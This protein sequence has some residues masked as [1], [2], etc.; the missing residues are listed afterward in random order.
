MAQ[1]TGLRRTCIAAAVLAATSLASGTALGQEGAALEEIVITGTRIANPNAASSSPVLAVTQENIRLQG[2]VDAG[3]LVDTLPQQITTVI[4]LSNTNNPLSGP[5]GITTMNLRGLGPQRTLVL[6]DGRRLGVGDPNSGNPNPSPDINQI[7]SALIERVDIVTGGASA[8]YGSDAI[9]GVA[10]FIMRR[11]F[12]G[13]Q[14]DAQ[15]GFNWHD[16]SNDYMQDLL[17]DGDLPSPSSNSTDGDELSVSVVVGGNFADGKGNA[18]GYLSYINANPT[19]LSER[20][21]SSCQLQGGG[22]FCGGSANS[23]YFEVLNGPAAG[24]LYSVFGEDLIDHPLVTGTD[25]GTNPPPLFNSNPYMNL[26]HG[27]ERYQGGVF[28]KYEW[29]E[30]ATLYTDFMF[31]KDQADTAVAPSGLFIGD[32]LPVFCNN[33]LLSAQQ[34]TAIGCTPA[35]IAAGDT[36]DMLIGR[37]NIEGGPRSFEYDHTNYRAMMGVRGDLNDA[38]SYDA[39][40][41]YYDTDLSNGNYGYIS[42]TRTL[43]GLNGCQQSADPT[44][45]AAGCVP[46]NIWRDGGVT[47]AA[48]DYIFAYGLATGTATQA[49]ANAGMTGDL[50][51]YGVQLPTAEEGVGVAFGA[52]YRRDTFGFTPDQTLGSG[53]LSGSGGASPTIN[54]D[55]DVTE[56]YAE[57][58]VPLVQGRAGA[59]DL[60]FET[61]YRYS[62]YEL[63]G[64]VDT[65]KFGLQWAPVESIRLRGSYN[66]AIRAPS[67]IELFN[68]Q[69]VTNTSV[70]SV[71]PCAG[72]TPTMS[73]ADCQRTGVTPAQYG[74]IP[75]CPAEQC[76][77]LTG[78]NPLV[79]P[80]TADTITFGF[81]LN[82][83]ALPDLTMSLDW[84]EIEVEDIIG[85][86]P[87]NEVFDGC[88]DGT[89]PEFCSMVVRSSFGGLFGQTIAGGGYIVGTNAN[90]AKATFQG[91]DAQGSYRF[92]IGS[93]GSL[94]A[95]LNAVYVMDT[96]TL[97]TPE[98]VEYDCAGLYG[99]QCGPAVPDWRHSLRLSW[100]FPGD[101]QASLQW[102]YVDSVG[103][104]ANSNQETLWLFDDEGNREIVE[105]GD[106][107]SARS[108]LDLAGTWDITDQYSLRAGINNLMDKDPPLVDTRWSGPGTPNTWGPYDTLGRTVF[109]A[110]TG[111]F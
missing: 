54:A 39:Y 62:D 109:F 59:Q 42:K 93:L 60:V 2:I 43:L 110:V 75:Q 8:V 97:A 94:V 52:E 28:A 33:S 32:V 26:K 38:W 47:T 31:M 41:S 5:G 57:F 24:N 100:L 3:D 83:T 107:L 44:D 90:V 4:D 25:P 85:N 55:T 40:G 22:A 87:L 73:L 16:N 66:H 92:D 96:K 70:F 11:D 61:G 6:V 20:D 84:Y 64:G 99:N 30:K 58:R 35:M 51:T 111:K 78:G 108:Y 82:P 65:Y 69:T 68:P 9:A 29:S 80:E 48:T 36:V 105:F 104:E 72:P 14:I 34:Q 76:A 89:H 91:V 67:L 49:I 21:F 50:G 74:N 53:D 46:Y 88:A 45:L 77:V 19:R 101:F 86:I 106:R 71:D 102:R 18:T 81:T 95:S 37:R 7:P 27:R 17:D 98:S 79:E 56:M 15:Y 12:E 1:L 103:H 63:S 23:N 13:V 10:N